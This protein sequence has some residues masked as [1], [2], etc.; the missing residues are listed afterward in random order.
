[1]NL[2]KDISP[3]EI[4][5]YSQKTLV[6]KNKGCLFMFLGNYKLELKMFEHGDS[7]T[8]KIKRF[9]IYNCRQVVD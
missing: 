5:L 8:T 7:W 1:M 9:E 3:E 2:S 4:I 6:K